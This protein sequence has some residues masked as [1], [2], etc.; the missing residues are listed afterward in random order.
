MSTS[1]NRYGRRLP[2]LVVSGLVVAA[3]AVAAVKLL[4]DVAVGALLG[5]IVVLALLGLWQ[6]VRYA[7]RTTAELTAVTR[8]LA[9][10]DRRADG[11]ARE[12]A[13]LSKALA[14]WSRDIRLAEV[15]TGIAALNRYVTLG[16][17]EPAR[18]A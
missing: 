10:A 3:V 16:A 8:A 17:D 4:G 7:Q 13:K 18:E 15:E 1:L 5:V 12:V 11:L 2:L 6:Q 14:T 9:D